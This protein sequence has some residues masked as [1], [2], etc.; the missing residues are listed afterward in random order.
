M[1]PKSVAAFAGACGGL[2]SVGCGWMSYQVTTAK[3]PGGMAALS[4]VALLEAGLTVLNVH[5]ARRAHG[6]SRSTEANSSDPEA[7]GGTYNMAVSAL[8][9]TF[10]AANGEAGT[11][12]GLEVVEQAEPIRAWRG[13]RLLAAGNTVELRSMNQDHGALIAKEEAAKCHATTP[14]RAALS[15]DRR[16]PEHEA[17][18]VGCSCGFYAVVDRADAYG[19]T[20]AEV[21]LYGTVIEHEK[22]Y[23]AQFQR[24]LSVRIK[25]AQCLGGFLCD[26][27]PELLAFPADKEGTRTTPVSGR[28]IEFAKLQEP[29]PVCKEH[30]RHFARVATLQQSAA[31]LGVEVRW[32]E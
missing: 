16:R 1:K 29:M 11:G 27:T 32:A 5:N 19:T 17:P 15:G 2:T 4:A 12:P 7:G 25:R 10:P 8:G 30:S 6:R 21:D 13:V 23:R 14:F 18:A 20:L 9:P 24:I 26:A 3:T 31:R 22:G 28:R